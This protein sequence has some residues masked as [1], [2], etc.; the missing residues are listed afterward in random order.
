MT[1]IFTTKKKAIENRK[2][3]EKEK[4]KRFSVGTNNVTRPLDR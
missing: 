4:K 1:E 3:K 2:K